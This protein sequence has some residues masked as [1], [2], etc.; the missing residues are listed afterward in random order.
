MTD[1]TVQT[2]CDESTILMAKKF[3]DI[4]LAQQSRI[5]LGTTIPGSRFFLD[6]ASFKAPRR[7]VKMSLLTLPS[8][9]LLFVANFLEVDGDIDSLAKTNKDVYSLLNPYLYRRNSLKSGSSALLWAAQGGNE[10]TAR[11][12]ISEGVNVGAID[13]V[14]RTPLSWAAQNRHEAVVNLLL[15][16][17]QFD[18][19]LKDSEGC[20]P[21]F[22]AVENGR[23]RVVKMLLATG[24][25]DVD[26]KDRLEI[27]PLSE[28]AF[29]GHA[30]I[31][32]PGKLSG[33]P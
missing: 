1:I 19:D 4:S 32:D 9:L 17:A 12:C 31:L 6:Q 8:E 23:E 13:G 26:S 10:A 21:L 14:D 22:S 29:R 20:T 16:T 25:R 24:R 30:R 18:I 27:T 2:I 11:R 15:A 28:A 3:P 33:F 7:N 5:S